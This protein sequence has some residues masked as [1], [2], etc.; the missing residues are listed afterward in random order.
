MKIDNRTDWSTAQLRAIIGKVAEDEVLSAEEMGKLAVTVDYRRKSSRLEDAEVSVTGHRKA[1]RLE[2]GCVKGA[3]LDKAYLARAVSWAMTVAQGTGYGVANRAWRSQPWREKFEWA[4]RMLLERTAPAVK[5]RPAADVAV[6][7]DI[8]HCLEQVVAWEQKAKLAK[9]KL[10]V[11]NRKLRYYTRKLGKVLPG[12]AAE[13]PG[14]S[15]EGLGKASGHEETPGFPK[16][17]VE[18]LGGPVG[19]PRG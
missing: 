3:E 4:K 14:T 5:E 13:G 11:W 10:A 16:G 15:Q 12:A 17:M 19:E 2:L 8:R 7:E 1:W 6:N 18:V 9:T